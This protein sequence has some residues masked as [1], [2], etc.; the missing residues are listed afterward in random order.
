L[1]ATLTLTLE[2]LDPTLTLELI[3]AA[4]MLEVDNPKDTLTLTHPA[5]P[6]EA[7]ESVHVCKVH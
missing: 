4:I 6:R 5:W 7:R 1:D 2:V 3:D